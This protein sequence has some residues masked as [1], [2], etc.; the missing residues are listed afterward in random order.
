MKDIC[1]LSAT[2]IA[3]MIKNDDVKSLD[4]LKSLS[5]R[6]EKFDEA[7]EAWEHFDKNFILNKAS[8]ADDHKNLGRDT[9]PLHGLP[10]GVKDIFGTN[11]MPTRCGT[12]IIGG[13]HTKNDASVVSFL[14]NSGAL[15]MGK[16][17]TTEFAYF[18]PGKTKNPHDKNRTPG[19]S[20]SGSAAAVASY[21]LSLIHI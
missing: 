17:V 20:S 16:T 10:I 13:V 8:E 9:G 12:N 21:M 15:I 11:D 19:G 18:D 4:V 1:F 3:R 7:V 2:E 5:T 6:I 14:R